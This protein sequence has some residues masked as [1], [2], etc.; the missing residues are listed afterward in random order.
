MNI[1]EDNLQKLNEYKNEPPNPSYIAGLID[2]DGT[3]FIRKIE[4]GYQSGISLSQ[5]RTNI[6]QI[7]RY[8]YGGTIVNPSDKDLY[9]LDLFNENGY[10][11]KLNKRNAY[12]LIIRS[13]EYKYILQDIYNHIILKR[14]Q[15]DALQD[16]QQ[17]VN[18]P[19]KMEDKQKLHEKCSHYNKIKVHEKYDYSK[20]NIEY[21]QGLFDAEGCM[22]VSYKHDEK[23]EIDGIKFTK[24]I[25]MKITQKSHPEIISEICKFLGFGKTSEYNYYVENFKDC[26]RLIKLLKPNL[27]IKYNQICAF[28]EYIHSRLE[29]SEKYDEIIHLK[30]ENLYK[31]INMEKHQIEVFEDNNM[32]N[33]NTKDGY[34]KKVHEDNDKIIL[35]KEE[36]NKEFYE[37]KSESMKGENHMYYGKHLTH[38]HALNISLA[39]TTAKR[40]KNENLTN[41]KIREIYELKD[42][43][44]QKDVAEKYGMN[45][46]M[47]R[48]IWNRILLPT[49]DAEF[50]SKKEVLVSKI[51]MQDSNLTNGQKTSTGKRTL[52]IE[53][54]ID[55]ISWKKRMNDGEKYD[56]KKITAPLISKILIEKYDKNVSVD[57]VKNISAGKTKLFEDEFKGQ[58]M[59]FEEYEEIVKKLV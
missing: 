28:E 51:L 42:K 18:K 16:F 25:Y 11:D 3:I 22:F 38:S 41:D 46:E 10:Y 54:Y 6:M 5:C 44:L 58:V 19:N 33:T 1:I 56:N 43:E 30:R 27:I 34:N 37:K 15:I 50:L 2:G 14:N 59:T 35:E 17:F 39:T 20:L 13:N 36:H 49:D 29:K 45:R 40:A 12:A 31:I 32:T 47:I 24:G 26:L 8:H 48:R 9:I 55:I 7:L 21:I 4:D 53:I 57:I 52:P 23:N